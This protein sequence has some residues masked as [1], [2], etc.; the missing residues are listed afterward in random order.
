V[1]SGCAAR[2]PARYASGSSVVGEQPGT[3][4]PNAYVRYIQSL[5]V[6]AHVKVALRG[7]ERFD[8]IFL[9]MQNSEV[10]LKPRTRIPEPERLVPLSD[11]AS[12]EVQSPS[13][14]IGTGKA[15]LIGVA[16]GA[17]TFLTLVLVTFALAWD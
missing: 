1:L 6:G 16:S 9:G 17:A 12:I 11:I 13:G 2:G 3:A 7:S 14:G 4:A 10:A 8:A 5:P 15:A